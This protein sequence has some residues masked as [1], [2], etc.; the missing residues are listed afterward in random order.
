MNNKPPA[1][2]S[3]FK[4]AGR[5]PHSSQNLVR[6]VR[7]AGSSGSEK[8]LGAIGQSNVAP[9]GP[10]QGMV[11]GLITV[12]HNLRSDLQAVLRHSTP[13]QRIRASTL[14]HPDFLLT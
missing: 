13:E 2:T 8:Q 12:H 7:R 6:V 9:V 1:C 14:Y 5:Q 3:F 11:P 4:N 10:E